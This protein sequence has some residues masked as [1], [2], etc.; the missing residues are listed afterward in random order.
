MT[1]MTRRKLAG[2][3]AAGLVGALATPA[4]AQNAT[5]TEFVSPSAELMTTSLGQ[6]A[7]KTKSNNTLFSALASNGG[8]PVGQK[9]LRD[10]VTEYE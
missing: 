9:P 10:T 7:V 4:L 6:L 1:K 8:R 3:G 2:A 5:S